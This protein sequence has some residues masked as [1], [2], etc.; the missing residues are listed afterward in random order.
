[1]T[2]QTA[3]PSRRIFLG[4][5]ATSSLAAAVG[6]A[7]PARAA[8][9]A[10]DIVNPKLARLG[11]KLAAAEAEFLTAG[12]KNRAAAEMFERM[13]PVIPDELVLKVEECF[14][15]Q[16]ELPVDLEGVPTEVPG[17]GMVRIFTVKTL[18]EDATVYNGRTKIGKLIRRKLPIAREYEA[19]VAHARAQSGIDAAH[20]AHSIAM[21]DL[22]R[23]ADEISKEPARTV[24]DLKVKAKAIS[25]VANF[26]NNRG[27]YSHIAA[28]SLVE[29]FL[30][31]QSPPDLFLPVR[32]S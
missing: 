10:D 11:E 15:L 28:F 32:T 22:E 25:V 30:R 27:F 9:S 3:S 18:S 14:H 19:G 20:C 2:S 5:F 4:R 13:A 29:E 26:P 12:G 23:V 17:Y 16:A 8:P 6:V 7:L 21:F 1:M 31:L 24:A